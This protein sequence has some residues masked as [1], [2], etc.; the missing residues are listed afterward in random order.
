[1]MKKKRKRNYI[2]KNEIIYKIKIIFDNKI[3]SFK[4]L[5]MY[6]DCIEQ[7]KFYEI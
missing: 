1:M 4:G 3:K 2:N 7:N 6:G 5:F